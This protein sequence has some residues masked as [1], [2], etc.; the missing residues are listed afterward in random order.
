M[1]GP[2]AG[3]GPACKGYAQSDPCVGGAGAPK[4]CWR[5]L[6][7]QGVGNKAASL[8]AA[9]GGHNSTILVGEQKSEQKRTKAHKSAQERTKAH[10]KSAPKRTKKRAKAHKSAQKLAKAHTSAQKRTRKRAQK[11]ERKRAQTSRK[12][13]FFDWPLW[14][15]FGPLGGRFGAGAGALFGLVLG[16]VW[17]RRFWPGAL[18]GPVLAP[19]WGRRFGA[20]ALW[21]WVG[22][23]CV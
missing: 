15:P 11:K 14:R 12:G 22:S 9:K 17:G 20:G 13:E 6:G 18:S 5:A 19:V 10:K 23:L 4:F 7:R 1:A 16:P 2:A 21:R 8:V 3:L